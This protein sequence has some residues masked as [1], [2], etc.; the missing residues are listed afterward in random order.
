[1]TGAAMLRGRSVALCPVRSVDLDT[2]WASHVDVANRGDFYPRGVVSETAFRRAH[3]EHGMW[4]DDEG[5]LLITVDGQTVGHIEFFKPVSYWDCFELS[6]QIYDHEHDGRGHVTE[7]V[8]LLVDYLFDTKR[9]GR[10]QLVIVP[11]NLASVR[12][13]EKCGFGLEG[14]ARG[15]FFNHGRNNDVLVFSLLRH[16]ARPWRRAGDQRCRSFDKSN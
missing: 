2:L 6:Y 13:A 5:M 10:I 3:A 7:A 4:Q 8:R 16:D 11:E 15:A 9:R 1:M 14:T 12:I